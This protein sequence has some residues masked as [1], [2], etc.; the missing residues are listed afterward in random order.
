MI[1]IAIC[2]DDQKDIDTIK[3]LL[4]VYFGNHKI[5]YKTIAFK[6]GEELFICKDRF[7]IV[8]LDISMGSGMNG[9]DVGKRY[10][11]NNRNAQIIYTT[12]YGEYFEE[13]LN[14][15]HAFAFL[16]KPIKFNAFNKQLNDAVSMIEQLRKSVKTIKVDIIDDMYESDYRHSR[17]KKIISLDEILYF[18]YLNREIIIKTF[19]DSY[20]MTGKMKDVLFEVSE[21]GFYKCHRSFIV[22]MK[23]IK[24]IDGYSAVLIDNSRVDIAQKKIIEFR[25]ALNDY[26]QRNL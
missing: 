23:H 7:D 5:E 22:N 16:V 8:F 6:S 1:H 11:I 15:V 13:A 4:S 21:Y 2:D 3:K 14:F 19:S 12:S 24:Y 18:E 26:I 9:I 20:R 25:E 10:R 17:R